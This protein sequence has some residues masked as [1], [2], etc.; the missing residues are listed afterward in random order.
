LIT[1]YVLSF[2]AASSLASLDTQAMGRIIPSK[3]GILGYP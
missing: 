3:Y 2:K 1:F